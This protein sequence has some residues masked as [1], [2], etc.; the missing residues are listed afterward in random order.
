M[1][2]NNSADGDEGVDS[3][4]GIEFIEFADLTYNVATGITTATNPGGALGG[5]G[6]GSSSIVSGIVA[7]KGPADYRKL[8]ES[9]DL[10]P[11]H[12]VVGVRLDTLEN[13]NQSLELLHFALDYVMKQR[14]DL[15]I[16]ENR[17]WFTLNGLQTQKDASL[18]AR[19]RITDADMAIEIK[20]LSRQQVLQQA[21]MQLLG[22]TS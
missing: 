9:G 13:A 7:G 22:K 16:A 14:I 6:S 19:S 3:L 21:G 20:T 10:V 12:S 1:T 17:L 4:S 8:V 2:D 11:L 5:G 18:A 15:G